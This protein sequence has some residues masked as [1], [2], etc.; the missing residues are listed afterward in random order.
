MASTMVSTSALR[1]VRRP[2]ADVVGPPAEAGSPSFEGLV[3]HGRVD[4]DERGPG[5]GHDRR[6]GAAHAARSTFARGAAAARCVSPAP[7]LPVDLPPAPPLAPP[8]LPAPPP[9]PA[10]P[11]APPLPPAPPDPPPPVAGP[12]VPVAPPEPPPPLDEP[13]APPPPVPTVPADPALADPPVP[14]GEPPVPVEPPS[15]PLPPVAPVPLS[16]LAAQAEA[17][18]ITKAS[19]AT[20][21]PGIRPGR[22]SEQE[23]HMETPIVPKGP[24]IGFWCPKPR[25]ARLAEVRDSAQAR[26]CW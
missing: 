26:P 6:P 25:G 17:R 23:W 9:D 11:L 13:P 10:P 16:L 24:W 21:R 5:R 3:V 22:P 7:P 1:F 15:A 14:L 20:I 4:L 8:L 2:T 12:P 18:P 19:V